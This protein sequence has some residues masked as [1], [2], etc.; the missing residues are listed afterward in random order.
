LLGKPWSQSRQVPGQRLR[1]PQVDSG[2]VA[3]GKGE[4][5]GVVLVTGCSS[6]IGLESALAFAREGDTTVATMRNIAKADLLRRRAADEGL[7]VHIEQLDVVRRGVG[8]RH[9]RCADSDSRQL[10]CA[11]QQRGCE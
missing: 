3:W 2:S 11:G 5:M 4:T 7:K 6:G 8:E 10:G 9:G 1:W